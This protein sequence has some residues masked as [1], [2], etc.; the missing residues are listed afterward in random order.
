MFLLIAIYLTESPTLE[1]TPDDPALILCT[2]GTT[3]KAKGAV[4][5]H[6]NV[7][8]IY[9][10]H[11][12]FP[13][14]EKPLIVSKGTHISGASIGLGNLASGKTTIV[15]WKFTTKDIFGS[16]HKYKVHNTGTSERHVMRASHLL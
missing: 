16:I 15:V 14:G 1:V 8:N 5:T 9:R 10:A 7:V 13:W 6:R 11:Q 2:S 4:R 3:G 12:V